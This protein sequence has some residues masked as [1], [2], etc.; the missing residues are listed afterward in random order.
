MVLRTLTAIARIPSGLRLNIKTLSYQ[1]MDSHYTEYKNPL[2]LD[3]ID[4][5]LRRMGD[6][7]IP[8]EVLSNLE[9][10]YPA[11]VVGIDLPQS[12]CCGL[13]VSFIDEKHI[14]T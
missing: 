3:V 12:R 9:S 10:L 13:F 8:D 11:W 1:Y 7:T 14:W 6:K 2:H 4:R 5:Y